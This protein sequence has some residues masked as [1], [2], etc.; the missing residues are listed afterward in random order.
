M[1]TNRTATMVTPTARTAVG[2]NERSVLTSL[3]ME[4]IDLINAVMEAESQF[5]TQN[6]DLTMITQDQPNEAPAN[7][8][9]NNPVAVAPMQPRR[10]GFAPVLPVPI[11]APPFIRRRL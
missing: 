6:Q 7:A 3:T 11:Q 5:E 8:P 4:E 10:R 1:A 9:P 2:N